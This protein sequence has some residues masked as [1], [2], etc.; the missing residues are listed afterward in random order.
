[1][2]PLATGFNGD[3]WC[4][5]LRCEETKYIFVGTHKTKDQATPW[6]ESIIEKIENIHCCKIRFLRLDGETSLGGIFRKNLDNRGIV[7]ERSAPH[8]QAQNGGAERSGQSL[9]LKGRTM[10]IHAN[11]PHNLWP[12][13]LPA[14]GY[15]MN[16]TPSKMI[17]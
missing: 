12:L 6:I 2:I 11:L 3:N 10:R 7:E 9:I 13:I 17:N 14:A 8:T 5:H 1:M 4:S 16:R 15:I